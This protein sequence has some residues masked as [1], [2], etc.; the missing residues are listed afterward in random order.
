MEGFPEL[1]SQF[2]EKEIMTSE[3]KT[4]L[5]DDYLLGRTSEE[6][7]RLRRQAMMWE[8]ATMRIFQQVGLREGM[9]CLDIGCGPGEVMRLMGE[10]VGTTGQVT[11]LDADGEFGRQAIEMLQATTKSS[12][13][14]I[15]QDIEAP[16]E[17][18]GQPFDLVYTRLLLS[19]ARD[20][21]AVLRKMYG[22]TRPGGHIVVQ[23]YDVR[24]TDIFPRLESLEEL[25][26]VVSGIFEQAGK[27]NK[28]GYKL[29]AYFIDADIG[30]PDGTDVTGNVGSLEE[31]G[32]W[33]RG[34][35]Q[36]ILP[37][38]IQSGLTTEA[39]GLAVLDDLS[40][41]ERSE[42]YYSVLLPL[43]IGVWKRKP[44]L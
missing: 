30:Y 25:K 20:P 17:I 11:G 28:I 32:W 12:F 39:E 21:I 40:R 29:P 2:S 44:P 27:D 3:Y 6:H 43:L 42:R 4:V 23:D 35:Y 37:R 1:P 10:L 31:Y 19:H 14:F 38:A 24:T 34:A 5:T 16:D 26:R 15:E 36:S 13:T 18:P 33:F 7:Q 8:P 9:Q 41:V 22:W